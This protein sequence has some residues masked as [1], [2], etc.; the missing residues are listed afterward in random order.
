MDEQLVQWLIHRKPVQ[1]AV[2]DNEKKGTQNIPQPLTNYRE[3]EIL[4]KIQSEIEKRE[5]DQAEVVF[6][7][8]TVGKHWPQPATLC[9]DCIEFIVKQRSI[10]MEAVLKNA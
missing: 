4:G 9:F 1:R 6:L 10:R 2:I 7:P 8:E 3:G 5:A